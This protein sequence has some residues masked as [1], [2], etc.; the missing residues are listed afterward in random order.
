MRALLVIAN[1]DADSFTHAAAERASQ[2]LRR[3]GHDVT[4]IDLYAVD[5]RA[6]M[7]LE[8]R[9]AYETE[10]P[11][12]DP[13]VAEHAELLRRAEMLVFVFPTWWNGLPAILKG[14]L[15]RTMV[16][17][18]AFHLDERTGRVRP[19]LRRVRRIV[20]ISTWG[21]TRPRPFP[22]NDDGRRVLTRALRMAC[23]WRARPLWLK[24]YGMDLD[25]PSARA[26]FLARIDERLAEL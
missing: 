24:L 5:F 12:V 16:P 18:V 6:A 19:G 15:D 3:N 11:I 8:E 7:S 20:G 23:G 25:D 22:V 17:G 1:P 21:M 14:W 26:R 9:I 13:R 2:T 10:D 4:A